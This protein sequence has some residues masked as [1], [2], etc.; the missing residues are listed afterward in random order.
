M[1]FLL[2]R[3][4]RAHRNQCKFRRRLRSLFDSKKWDN[5]WAVGCNL[6]CYRLEENSGKIERNCQLY[7]FQPLQRKHVRMGKERHLD[8]ATGL[9]RGRE[10]GTGGEPGT[11]GRCNSRTMKLM[12]CMVS[13]CVISNICGHLMNYATGVN[14]LEA[15][16]IFNGL[17]NIHRWLRHLIFFT[18]TKK[19]SRT[20]GQ[21]CST[22]FILLL[23]LLIM[24]VFGEFPWFLSFLECVTLRIVALALRL[25]SVLWLKRLEDLLLECFSEQKF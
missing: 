8:I 21:K 3:N 22:T 13:S 19:I 16:R 24:L 23:R 15:S 14:K 25:S 10:T 2:V 6:W 4:R 17:E 12:M 1:F 7:I 9:I 20:V 5:V 11:P 18:L